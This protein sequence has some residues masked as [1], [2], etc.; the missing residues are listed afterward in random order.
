LCMRA[1]QQENE[2]RENDITILCA[3]LNEV[4]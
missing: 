2:N 4:V 3:I 1:S